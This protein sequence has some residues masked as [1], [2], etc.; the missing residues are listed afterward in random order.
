MNIKQ[1]ILVGSFAIGSQFIQAQPLNQVE[2]NFIQSFD[3]LQSEH[4]DSDCVF[5]VYD[6]SKESNLPITL[7]MPAG[8]DITM[9]QSNPGA[10]NV[11]FL[12]FD[13]YT[14]PTSSHWNKT[15]NPII[16][17][18][19]NNTEEQIW[20]TWQVVAEDFAPFNVNVTTME[21][22]FG[23]VGINHRQRCVI[24]P[25]KN[26]LSNPAVGGTALPSS[27]KNN[28]EPCFTF[29]QGGIGAGVTS[30]HEVGHTLGL[31]HDGR[32]EPSEGYYAGHVVWAPIMGGGFL[33]Y[34]TW[35]KGEYNK[36]NNFQDDL[37]IMTGPHQPLSYRA[38]DHGNTYSA[39]TN[40]VVDGNGVFIGDN[41]KGIIEQESDLDVFQFTTNGN[42]FRIELKVAEPTNNLD[43][44]VRIL[45]SS[46]QEL[47]VYDPVDS[48]HITIEEQLVAGTYFIEI[49]GVGLKNPVTDGYSDYASI[50]YYELSGT[51]NNNNNLS[52]SP[53]ISNVVPSNGQTIEVNGQTLL[54]IT[55]NV[56]DFDGSL[57]SVFFKINGTNYVPMENNGS[58]SLSWPISTLGSISLE[59]EAVDNNWNSTK[60]TV[61][62]SLINPCQESISKNGWSIHSFTSEET[63]NGAFQANNLIDGQNS[64]SWSTAWN[65][66]ELWPY[67]IV[68]NMGSTQ[69]VSGIGLHFNNDLSSLFT[70]KNLSV[71]I[72]DNAS[73]WGAEVYHEDLPTS[74]TPASMTLQVT[75]KSGRYIKLQINE[76]VGTIPG[77]WSYISEL[78]VFQEE[79]V[80]KS[81]P[82]VNLLLP[83][84]DQEFL[85]SQF[86]PITLTMEVGNVYGEVENIYFTI[87]GVQIPATL[88]GGVFS[89]TW[90]PSSHGDI[91]WTGTITYDGQTVS[92]SAQKFTLIDPCTN[93]LPK[94]TW[95]ILNFTSEETNT[96]NYVV[97]NVI[98]GDTLTSWSTNQSSGDAWP[99]ELEIDLGQSYLITGTNFFLE[100]NFPVQFNYHWHAPSEVEVFISN[101]NNNWGASVYRT[102]LNFGFENS[103]DTYFDE[104]EGRYVKIIIHSIANVPNTWGYISEIDIYGGCNMPVSKKEISV[105]SAKLAV[106]PNPAYDIA[107]I[108]FFSDKNENTTWFLTDLS[109]KTILQDNF[110]L[111]KGLNSFSLEV[112]S[113][114]K[115]LYFLNIIN[116]DKKMRK[117]VMVK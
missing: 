27:F 86:E 70:A 90:T 59:I 111:I 62:Y 73:N 65:Q 28:D 48:Y 103:I 33:Q 58:Y 104:V 117:K 39:A 63:G 95:N 36:A 91:H 83:Q 116:K 94:A 75:P 34:E 37:A 4:K 7:S 9:L 52:F 114:K 47:S 24:T 12:D 113:L 66:S 107:T 11:I 77:T 109:G 18:P 8:T 10:V 110:T 13:G 64:S 60:K 21:S 50:G 46:G 106:Y 40:L 41:N 68:V 99:F 26:W 1:S 69:N 74:S 53:T 81:G 85:M 23:S 17:A 14:I 5:P 30:S 54:G 100:R 67:E 98:D 16:C 76:T 82:Q 96:G 3:H 89:A 79:C 32:S 84:I 15:S 20:E 51:L 102:H 97:A 42:P 25:T 101:S 43:P 112:K 57:N 87:D 2:P 93:K 6:S 108:E 115:G 105:D 78:D 29:N 80:G 71:F 49:D 22:V 56:A 35:S 19:T 31:S 92:S 44:A 61:N 55:A 45:N 72:S 88:Q 38:D